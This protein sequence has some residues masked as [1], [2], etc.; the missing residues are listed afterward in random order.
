MKMVELCRTYLIDIF[1]SLY[2]KVN[3]NAWHN[4]K[5]YIYLEKESFDCYCII[6]GLVNRKKFVFGKILV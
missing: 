2:T 4:D 1:Q 6:C 3:E 5:I